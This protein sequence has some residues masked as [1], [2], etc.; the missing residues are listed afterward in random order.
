MCKQVI[1]GE[2]VS[3]RFEL[4]SVSKWTDCSPLD[5]WMDGWFGCNGQSWFS[6]MRA[7][8]FIRDHTQKKV[9]S[10][11]RL[12]QWSWILWMN[13]ECV[14][15]CVCVWMIQLLQWTISIRNA[16]TRTPQILPIAR[17]KNWKSIFYKRETEW[18]NARMNEC[19]N[20]LC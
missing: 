20:N 12:I 19:N 9:S 14:C 5:R 2:L 4:F 7:F 1:N 17:M 18:L 6:S 16:S 15:V 8:S 13:H 10:T 3:I 11:I